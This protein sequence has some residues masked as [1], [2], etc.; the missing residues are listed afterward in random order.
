MTNMS[1]WIFSFNYEIKILED[2]DKNRKS[3]SEIGR[4]YERLVN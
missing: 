3:C 1:G 2:C 4:A